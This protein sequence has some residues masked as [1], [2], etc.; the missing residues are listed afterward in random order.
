MKVGLITCRRVISR[1]NAKIYRG[2][3][4]TSRITR[5]ECSVDYVVWEQEHCRVS[6]TQHHRPPCVEP[7]AE[8]LGGV[9]PVGPCLKVW[10]LL[11]VSNSCSWLPRTVP[12]VSV[13]GNSALR[14]CETWFLFLPLHGAPNAKGKKKNMHV[15]TGKLTEPCGQRDLTISADVLGNRLMI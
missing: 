11:G 8:I 12:K 5:Q 7:H 2:K 14:T 10:H 13:G 15:F 6:A 3:N 9:L 4:L 1:W